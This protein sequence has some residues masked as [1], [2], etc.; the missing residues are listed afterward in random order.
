VDEAGRGP[1]AGPVVAAAVVLAEPNPVAGLTDSKKLSAKRREAL[2]DALMD[3]ALAAGLGWAEADEIDAVNIRQATFRA[4]ERAVA[5]LGAPPAGVRIDGNARPPG[6]PDAECL[7][8][9]DA[10]DPAIAAASILAKVTR[11]RWM[12]D[13]DTA[14]PGYGFAGH[15]GYGTAAHR[16]AVQRLGPSP[17]HRR[18]FTIKG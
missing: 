11:D 12:V 13:Y 6:L 14:Y 5:A 4:M 7:V 3:G 9:G 10:A 15:K 16:E 8:G 17:I 18:S 2:H 1:L